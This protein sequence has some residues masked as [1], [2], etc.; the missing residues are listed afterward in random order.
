MAVWLV[1]HTLFRAT[2]HRDSQ[3]SPAT[4]SIAAWTQSPGWS[5]IASLRFARSNPE[6]V[7]FARDGADRVG[8]PVDDL[9]RDAIERVITLRSAE[10]ADVP[11]HAGR[12]LLRAI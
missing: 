6:L 3:L 11:A 9:L 4:R 8:V 12:P 2:S 10:R 5:S 1:W 7:R